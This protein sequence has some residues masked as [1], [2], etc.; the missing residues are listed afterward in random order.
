MA[1]DVFWNDASPPTRQ[2]EHVAVEWLI[3]VARQLGITSVTE[4][5]RGEWL[6]RFA[7]I[8]EMRG[9]RPGG[10]KGY[11]RDIGRLEGILSRFM[12]ATLEGRV[13]DQSRDEFVEDFTR[14][15]IDAAREQADAIAESHADAIA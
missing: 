8:Q 1:T 6:W 12:T 7:F 11:E 4:A 9:R 2:G 13:A 10:V 14:Q 5:N 3:S 15:G